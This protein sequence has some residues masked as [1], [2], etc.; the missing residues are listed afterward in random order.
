MAATDPNALSHQRGTAALLTA[1][2][3]VFQL[4][5]VGAVAVTAPTA[6]AVAT[7]QAGSAVALTGLEVEKKSSPVGIDVERPRFSWIIESDA[8][9]VRQESYRLRVATSQAELD[10]GEL[11][12][13]SGQVSSDRSAGVE[14]DGPRMASATDYVWSVEVTTNVGTASA[15]THLRTGF[16]DESDWADSQWIGNERIDTSD[17]LTLAGASW[18][19]TP[20]A[21]S[22]VAPAEP[23]AFRTTRTPPEG[24]TAQSAEIL[25]TADDLFRLWV[26]GD[27]I[28]ESTVPRTSGSSRTST[29]C[30][31]TPAATSSRSARTTAPGRPQGWSRR[32]G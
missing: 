8:R 6:S 16:Y 20:E 30:S 3:L 27:F 10:A 23:R 14:Y 7:S 9:D 25:I 11:S 13:D 22:P 4:A 17:D 26:N 24:R 12:W 29:P 1:L 2:A 31:S 19:W 18:I 32:C 5:M 15:A 21:T 28:G